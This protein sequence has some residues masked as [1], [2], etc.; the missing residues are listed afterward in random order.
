MPSPAQQTANIAKTR[1]LIAKLHSLVMQKYESYRTRRLPIS[2]PAMVLDSTNGPFDSMHNPIP[3]PTPARA[4][5]LVRCDVMRQLMRMEMPERWSD[6]VDDPQAITVQQPPKTPGGP[7][8]LVYSDVATANPDGMGGY[9]PTGPAT[10]TMQRP[11]SSLAYLAFYNSVYGA[12]TSGNDASGVARNNQAAKCLYLMITLGLDEPDVLE[13]FSQQD[14]GNA[15]PDPTTGKVDTPSK[16]F[17]DAWGH[18]I[19]FLRWAPGLVSSLQPDAPAVAGQTDQRMRDQTDPTG[20]Y[21]FPQPGSLIL[22]PATANQTSGP[23]RIGGNTFALYPLI[24][25]AG[26][27][28]NY[29]LVA[30]RLDGTG[31]FHCASTNPLNNPFASV[32]DATKFPCPVPA[33]AGQGGGPFGAPFCD[34]GRPFGTADNITNQDVGAR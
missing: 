24:W 2:I 27:D 29:D 23:G 33:A 30:E 15:P 22:N 1:S 14:I 11:S 20:V 19:W 5:A 31:S 4:I 16:V 21:G 13:N 17:L 28:G 25:S 10:V 18:P 9:T 34:P 7:S 12:T 3:I 8:P 32:T 26:P 6:I